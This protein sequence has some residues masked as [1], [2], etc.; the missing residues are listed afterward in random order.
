MK[1]VLAVMMALL[2]TIATSPAMA[3]TTRTSGYYTY[4]IKGN[5]TIA[6]TDYDYVHDENADI[7]IP[8]M[9][10]G[11][12]VTEI[13]DFAFSPVEEF[14]TNE[15][16]G[17]TS[18]RLSLRAVT[19]PDTITAIGEFAFFRSQIR[20]INIPKS[21]QYIGYGAF[22]CCGA[23][24]FTI[25]PN[26]EVF[27]VIDNALY[28]KSAK[29]LL[30]YPSGPLHIPTGIVSIA[31]YALYGNGV[32]A[33]E[34]GLVLPS[35]IESIGNYAFAESQY[36]VYLSI[37]ETNL[38]SIGDYAFA[39]TK[40]VKYAIPDSVVS[41]GIGAF[42]GDVSGEIKITA[43]SGLHEIPS[44]TFSNNGSAKISI[45][46]ENIDTIGDHAFYGCKEYNVTITNSS[47]ITRIGDWCFSFEVTNPDFELSARI[48]TI[49][50][51]FNQHHIVLSDNVRKIEE[52][53]Y[54]EVVSDFY[55]PSSLTY[56][57]ENAFTEKKRSSFVVEKGSYA[58]TWV[59]E[60][61][62]SY[63]YSGQDNLDWLN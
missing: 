22:S 7:Y 39:G 55:L 61:G 44:Y 58:E 31:D 25:D 40:Q 38:Q 21:V 29:E 14:V 3:D 53:A 47:N 2:L 16:W 43:D 13:G 19:I 62:L 24:K 9:I 12:T 28:N 23:L 17:Q 10:D 54:S 41:L 60:N 52:A 32:N 27:A 49:P 5:G 57:D 8:Q 26:H 34:C 59:R 35:T 36:N 45:N 18:T 37:P 51:G 50:T 46:A 33:K 15:E 30:C 56:I 11:Y 1:K 63:T 4:K 48:S 42:S 20:S 6:I